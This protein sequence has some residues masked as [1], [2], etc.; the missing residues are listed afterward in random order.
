MVP[1]DV[2]DATALDEARA[3][4]R[5]A[6]DDPIHATPVALQ[7]VRRAH[8]ER[9]LEAAAI[10]ER[11][12][13]YSLM[14]CGDMDAAIRHLRR[15]IRY[16]ERAKSQE[17]VAKAR[18]IL[19]FALNQR[20][21]T[22]WA[23]RE[24]DAALGDLDDHSRAKVLAQRGVIL[25]QLGR[26][27]DALRDYQAALP[28][29]RRAG[30]SHS[31]QRTLVNRGILHAERYAFPP[32]IA[33][34]QEAAQ[35]CRKHDRELAL[36]IV[37]A[38]LG[39]VMT[40]RGDVPAA[41]DYLDR[42]EQ[43]IQAQSGLLGPVIQDRCSL[44]LS[45]GLLTEA[46][47]D[48]GR[49]VAAY[50]C[51]RRHLRLPE[52]RLQLAQVALLSGDPMEAL[53]HARTAT[54]E[55][56]GQ[57][58]LEWA[59]LAQVTV[60]RARLAANRPSRI[61]SDQLD[62][63]A[64]TLSDAGWAAAALECRLVAAELATR[65]GHHDQARAQLTLARS[66]A[67]RRPPA[68][69]R[70]RAMYGTALLRQ[71]MGDRAGAARAARRGLRVLDD[72]IVALGASDLRAHMALHRSDLVEVGLRGALESGRPSAVFEWAERG[73]ASH[74]LQRPARP[75][76]DPRCAR[77]LSELRSVASQL[78]QGGGGTAQLVQRQRRL[79]RQIRDLSRRQRDL[80]QEPLMV[81][82]T[83]SALGDTLGGWALVEFFHLDGVLYGLCVVGGRVRL[84]PVGELRTV[85][86]L[87]QRMPFALHR[88][89][90]SPTLPASTAAGLSLLR[91]TAARLDAILLRPFAAELADRPLAVVPTGPLHGLP[92][93]TLPSCAG[94]PLAVAPSATLSHA[95]S[96]RVRDRAGVAS[97][98]GPKLSGAREEAAAVA[99]I[100]GVTALV[101]DAATAD[102]TL[103]ALGTAELVHLAAHGTL[104]AENPQF[105]SLL[106]ADGPLMV[107]DLEQLPQMPHT[108]VL[109]ACDSGRSAVRT[110][111][112]LLGLSAAFM[113]RGAAQIIASV[114][115]IPDAHTTALMVSFHR[116][117]VL[118]EPP[119]AALSAAQQRLTEDSPAALAAAAGFLCFGAGTSAPWSG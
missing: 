53:R 70:A 17:S 69:L 81:P 98:A 5:L 62:A 2:T 96:T 92:W 47:A 4:M 79:E 109:S 68:T 88:L 1:L 27:D 51:E 99:A 46:R 119:A 6:D 28:V 36:G 44:L 87:V 19:A 67:L 33:D 64:S 89:A 30:D 31:V 106:M 18:V 16:G 23:L 38:N 74:L 52:A 86:D 13:G 11:A 20:G 45:A 26:L 58:R 3:A 75:P 24:I 115:P 63:I 25:W 56:K 111:D 116:R 41:L 108:V 54:R 85:L 107:Y 110:G 59:A 8:R 91:D 14:M 9:N 29:L 80:S 12:L 66:T 43:R 37:E 117:L 82:V 71:S 100:H 118:G 48:A 114:V 72:H 65:R 103:T 78:D 84:R 93:S 7:A 57:R 10:A 22:A 34:L 112:V 21:R 113:A 35:L 104:V 97:A 95:G 49:A 76:T 105:S 83:V 102:A 42:A 77:L 15:A 60:L 90:A 40:L 73:K 50:Q 61:H 32:A 94:R 55:F 39:W 101:D